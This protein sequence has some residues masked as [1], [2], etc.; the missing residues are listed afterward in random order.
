MA[1]PRDGSLPAVS[2]DNDVAR[3]SPR[4]QPAPPFPPPGPAR[5][6]SASHPSTSARSALESTPEYSELAE[7]VKRT[8]PHVVRLVV[9]NLSKLCLLGSEYHL[10]FLVSLRLIPRS[11]PSLAAP[12]MVLTSASQAHTAFDQAS[13]STLDRSVQDF[14][15]KMV[16]SSKRHIVEHLTAADFDEV[17]DAILAKVSNEFLDKALARRLETI[18]ARELVNAL[19]RAER[20]GYDVQDIVEEK[21]ANG[22]EHVVPCFDPTTALSL[23]AQPKSSQPPRTPQPAVEPA[24]PQVLGAQSGQAPYDLSTPRPIPPNPHDVSQC[25]RCGRFCS[26]EQALRYVSRSSVR[27]WKLGSL[28]VIT[29]WR[30]TQQGVRV[31][32][33]PWS[34]GLARTYVLIAAA[35]LSAVA[36]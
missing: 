5:P 36:A 23:S 21:T 8:S 13:S 1:P 14:G 15:E 32:T 6:L 33:R 34:K 7:A 2:L 30:S 31:N 29:L 11:G 25:T 24:R 3:P 17:A 16:K 18:R 28:T 9:R 12:S 27:L 19:A 20:L 22:A 10:S 35:S 26:G 4:A